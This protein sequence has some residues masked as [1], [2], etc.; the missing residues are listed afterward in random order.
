MTDEQLDEVHGGAS[1]IFRPPTQ[2][3]IAI[4][5]PPSVSSGLISSYVPPINK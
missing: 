2:G 5:P 1:D 3:V 4:T